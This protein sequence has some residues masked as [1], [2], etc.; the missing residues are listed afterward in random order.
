MKPKLETFPINCFFELD[1][2]GSRIYGRIFRCFVNCSLTI[3]RCDVLQPCV[4]SAECRRGQDG[5]IFEIGVDKLLKFLNFNEVVSTEANRVFT[6]L[7]KPSPSFDS[8]NHATSPMCSISP[9]TG[10]LLSCIYLLGALYANTS[11][12]GE[13]I[14]LLENKF[15]AKQSNYHNFLCDFIYGIYDKTRS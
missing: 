7:I 12:V 15:Y 6:K 5:Q 1:I 9:S 13:E 11:D 8:F 3:V 2:N 4:P 10:G 14:Y